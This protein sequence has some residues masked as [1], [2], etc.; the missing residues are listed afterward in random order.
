MPSISAKLWVP[1][2]KA[3]T[4]EVSLKFCQKHV[5]KTLICGTYVNKV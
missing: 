3:D 4:S 1:L 2:S 5:A